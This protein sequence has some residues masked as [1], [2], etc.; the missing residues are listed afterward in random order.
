V[1][2]CLD[3]SHA[4]MQ[5]HDWQYKHNH[6]LSHFLRRRMRESTI[7][8]RAVGLSVS[9]ARCVQRRET[10]WCTDQYLV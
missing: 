4:E 9:L 6:I 8:M 5:P 1:N 10:V 7:F 3:I 2:P